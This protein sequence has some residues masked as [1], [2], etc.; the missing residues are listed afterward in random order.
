MGYIKTRIRKVTH[1]AMPLDRTLAALGDPTRREILRRLADSPRRAGE[2]AAGFSISRPAVCKH[3]RL[4]ARA[5]LI[6]ASKKGRERIYRLA[7]SGRKA[8]GDA[9]VQLQD[10][11]RYW[12]FVLQAFKSHVEKKR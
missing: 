9:V 4:L 12:D 7:P 1:L 11:E 5:G 6:H 8:V 2:L 10:L 3:T